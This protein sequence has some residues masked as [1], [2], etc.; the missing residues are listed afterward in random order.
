M[1]PA[2]RPAG[3]RDRS[4]RRKVLLAILLTT[5]GGVDDRVAGLEAAVCVVIHALF[6]GDAWQRFEAAR[7][8]RLVTCNA[9]PH[10]TNAI[11]LSEPI[12]EAVRGLL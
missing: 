5:M 7:P 1:T 12:A 2:A 11:D 6:S 8:A 9:V 10:L 4:L 3:R